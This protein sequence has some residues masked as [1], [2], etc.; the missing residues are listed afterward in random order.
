MRRSLS[1]M[2]GFLGA[3]AL[4]CVAPPTPVFV[5]CSEY[6][7]QCDPI[8][9]DCLRNDSERTRNCG[10]STQVS[11]TQP[12]SR[13]RK[14]IDILFVI[15]NAAQM[16]KKQSALLDAI[17]PFLAKLEA[18][19]L[20]YHLGII[21]SDVGTNVASGIRWRSGSPS[22]DTYA[23][24]DGLL[25]A[26]PCSQRQGLSA[27]AM[28]AC[29]ALCP[30]DK[31][32][33]QNG[34]RYISRIDGI[35][36]VPRDIRT[37]TATGAT[38]DL[39]PLH[40]LRCM[41]FVG[42]SGCGVT[43]PLEASK[44]ALDSHRSENLGFL[45]ANSQLV[46]VYLADEDDCSVQ[47]AQRYQNNPS[48]RACDPT[49]PD[50]AD[51]YHVEFRCFARSM[52]CSE[53]LLTPGV[54]TNCT[55]RADSYL[56]P[57]QKYQRFFAALRPA[58]KLLIAGI[59]P[60]PSISEGGRVEVLQ[61]GGTDSA[62]LSLAQA[63][64]AA[65][66]SATDPLITGTAQSRLSEFAHLLGSSSAGNPVVTETSICANQ[67][68]LSAFQ[69]ID[70]L[71]LP[72]LRF[73]CLDSLPLHNASGQPLCV[74]GQVAAGTPY[75]FPSADEVIPFCSATCCDGFAAASS[76]TTQDPAISAA[77]GSEPKDCACVVDGRSKGLCDG[78]AMA[79]IWRKQA[80]EPAGQTI[81]IHCITAAR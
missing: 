43:S 25:Q 64:G 59:W 14:D 31:Y 78:T 58:S 26:I 28:A 27:E 39:G 79:G 67:S 29:A 51:C 11:M 22:C 23:G 76:P 69:A 42:D 68:D 66:T 45:R 1:V 52:T 65:C 70:K 75:K 12:E 17:S 30:D 80:I 54:K 38:Q 34:Q 56:E 18:S 33:P 9:G 41:G 6:L 72:P 71:L 36:N 53:S 62:N 8:T 48:V 57:V 16:A 32:V 15:D 24:D 55:A 47:L 3:T 63:G 40:A 73:D 49:K 4:G 21:T 10:D 20:N 13:L 19:H 37:D 2:F 50:A 60:L 77:C 61:Q 7:A 74:V 81:N 46:V 44:R 35:S 5:E